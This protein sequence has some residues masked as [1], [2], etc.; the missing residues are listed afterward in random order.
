MGC[1]EDAC[2]HFGWTKVPGIHVCEHL[3]LTAKI[4]ALNVWHLFFS[5]FPARASA[6]RSASFWLKLQ[7]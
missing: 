6:N 7:N 3:P 2:R 1:A 4:I 5:S